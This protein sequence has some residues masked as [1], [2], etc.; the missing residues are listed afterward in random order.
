M[1]T[2]P[3]MASID[4]HPTQSASTLAN[5]A[6][7]TMAFDEPETRHPG[8]RPTKYDPKFCDHVI[9]WGSMGKSRAWMAAEMNVAKSTV[10]LWE[11]EHPEFSAAMERAMTLSQRWW[12]DKGQ[13]NIDAE[14]FQASMWSRSMAARFPDDW[15]ETSRQEQSGV[16]GKP[17]ETTT[18]I[19][20]VVVEPKPLLPPD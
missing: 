6:R 7:E 2:S 14:K 18:R 17:I 10:Q 13:E 8:G 20:W 5:V 16:E 3:R 12:E 1:E 11:K 19:E 15:R 9:E 4:P